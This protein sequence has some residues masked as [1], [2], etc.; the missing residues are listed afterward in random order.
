MTGRP[1][2]SLRR[3]AP[4]RL[5]SAPGWFALVAA[6][7]ALLTAAVVAPA[8]FLRAANDAAL[9]EELR[10]VDEDAFA[11]TSSAVRGTW[12]GVLLPSDYAT[13]VGA[14]DHLPGYG[15]PTV[16]ALGIGGSSRNTDSVAE[17]GRRQQQASLYYRDGAI[18]A[19][20]PTGKAGPGVW[21]DREV[22]AG[23]RIEVGDVVALRLVSLG[24]PLPPGYAKVAG[25]FDRAPG[26]ALPEAVTRTGEVASR[27]L[28]WDPDRPGRGTPIAL[29]DV[30]TF[31]QVALAM[32]EQVLWTA[33]ADLMKDPSPE[34]AATAAKAVQRLGNKAFEDGSKL[35]I[36][37]MSAKPEPSHLDVISG[38]PDIVLRAQT[39]TAVARNQS[40]AFV[41]AGIALG[42]IVVCAAAVLLGRS[43]RREQDLMAG[44]GMRPGEVAGLAALEALLPVVVGRRRRC[45]AGLADGLGSRAARSVPVRRAG[46][47]RAARGAGRGRRA[48]AHGEL[49]RGRGMAQRP[50]YRRPAGRPATGPLAGGAAG[51]DGHRRSGR[52]DDQHPDPALDSA[53]RRLPR[54]ARGIGGTDRAAAPAAGVRTAAAPGPAGWPALARGA[55]GPGG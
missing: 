19:L 6:S 29:A 27:D 13:V 42:V 7:V 4:G 22:A 16:S 36:A 2:H 37:T 18:E 28:P 43:R 41:G 48:G 12:T 17:F 14:I 1:T 21:L 49:R 3:A 34:Q 23:L 8:L 35:S 50:A 33:D 30:A 44:L 32:L 15:H 40:S 47:G 46:A 20:D 11:S 54:A 55:A 9:T 24:R 10:T 26:S 5:L 39:T 51:R 25:I 53:R 45:G 52:D 31:N 38:L